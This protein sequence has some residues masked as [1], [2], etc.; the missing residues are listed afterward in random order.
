MDL[1]DSSHWGPV[2]ALLHGMDR[3]IAELYAE[4]GIGDVRTRFVGPMIQLSRQ[5]PQ[6]IQEL[7]D[8]IAVTHSAMSQT[9]AAMRRAGLVDDAPN[10]DGRTRRIRLS[11]RGRELVPFLAA[12]WRAT[13]ATVRQLDAELPYALSTVV[14]D[15]RRALERRSFRDR[16]RANFQL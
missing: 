7:A 5:E 9:V 6:S 12:E 8:R 14:E 11:D 13:E 1:L 10:V 16:L 15:I 3:E 4:A 2:W